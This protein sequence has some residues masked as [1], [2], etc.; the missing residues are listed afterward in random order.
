MAS[1]LQLALRNAIGEAVYAADSGA[2]GPRDKIFPRLVHDAETGNLPDDPRDW[3]GLQ[4]KYESQNLRPQAAAKCQLLERSDYLV[5]AAR[6]GP[7]DL[8]AML[9]RTGAPEPPN[10]AD[11]AQLAARCL[12]VAMEHQRSIINKASWEP[13][14]KLLREAR[15]AQ[16]KLR[17][18]MPSLIALWKR[19]SH[20]EDMLRVFE[21]RMFAEELEKV[22][23]NKPGVSVGVGRRVWE[24][25]AI[26]LAGVYRDIV[27]PNTGWSRNGPAVRFLV[28]ALRRAYPGT[29]PTAAAIESLLARRGPESRV[30]RGTQWVLD[31]L[32][33]IGTGSQ[34]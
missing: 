2:A 24:I 28:E 33:P 25:G 32:R 31:Q 12:T 18:L 27:N 1:P 8:A 20:G 5:A 30:I 7:A 11:I 10:S 22:D 21:Y 17:Q 9:S 13:Y 29:N 26:E 6:L 4:L 34:S 15:E 3:F 23:F 16:R 19:S 14:N